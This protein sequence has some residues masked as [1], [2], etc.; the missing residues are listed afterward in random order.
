MF[1]EAIAELES[2]VSQSGSSPMYVASLA[3]AYGV[4]GRRSDALKSI[5]ELHKLSGCRYVGSFTGPLPLWLQPCST[6][7]PSAPQAPRREL[8]P[9]GLDPIARLSNLGRLSVR[10]GF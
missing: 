6:T 8:W 3:H 2:A 9:R 5:E 10:P 1:Q 4:A 7:K